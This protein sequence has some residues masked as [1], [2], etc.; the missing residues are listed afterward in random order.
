[1]KTIEENKI[2]QIEELDILNY[3]EDPNLKS[4][5]INIGGSD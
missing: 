3:L 4:C 1:M 5:S 2:Y